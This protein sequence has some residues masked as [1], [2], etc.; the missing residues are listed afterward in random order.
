M[1]RNLSDQE[2]EFVGSDWSQIKGPISFQ[3]WKTKDAF[4][5][6][7]KFKR[8]LRKGIANGSI[9][10]S[11]IENLLKFVK[12]DGC[13]IRWKSFFDKP[14]EEILKFYESFVRL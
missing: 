2:I 12:T 11:Q 8:K 1:K 13:L 10:Q 14:A 3:N 7:A 4:L 6:R 9:K 5:S